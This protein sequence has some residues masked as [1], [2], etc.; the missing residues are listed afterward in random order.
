MKVL[1]AGRIFL[2]IGLLL[3]LGISLSGCIFFPFRERGG[4]YGGGG[5][6]MHER[7]EMHEGHER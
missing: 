5:G 2:N 3:I 6:G 4:Y 7:G 1:R